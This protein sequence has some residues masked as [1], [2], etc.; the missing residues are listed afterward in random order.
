MLQRPVSQ[1]NVVL[2]D[3]IRFF[4]PAANGR[5]AQHQ[6]EVQALGENA[7]G[8]CFLT[9]ICHSINKCESSD[10]DRDGGGAATRAPAAADAFRMDMI[11]GLITRMETG[12][13]MTLHDWERRVRRC[14][15]MDG[16]TDALPLSSM[17]IS[18][19]PRPAAMR[20]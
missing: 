8:V 9:G 10:G 3:R 2:P 4:Y 5:Q 13:R 12:E 18:S 20:K 16:K 14:F 1:V 11:C 6:L 19:N 15:A 17:L 7:H